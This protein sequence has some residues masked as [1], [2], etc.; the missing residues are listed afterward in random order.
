MAWMSLTKSTGLAAGGGS[1][2]ASDSEAIAPAHKSP[3]AMQATNCA[4]HRINRRGAAFKGIQRLQ[5]IRL[6]RAN[7]SDERLSTDEFGADIIQRA[8]FG[9]PYAAMTYHSNEGGYCQEPATKPCR[10]T[11]GRPK[12]P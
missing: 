4:G 6:R 7:S 3:A 5:R 11:C 1:L 8:G 12:R 9:K 2:E 10:S